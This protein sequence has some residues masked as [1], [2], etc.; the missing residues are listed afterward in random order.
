VFFERKKHDNIAINHYFCAK[1]FNR[2][3]YSYTGV[4]YYSINEKGCP[5]NPCIRQ[6]SK[7]G[8]QKIEELSLSNLKTVIL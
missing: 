1:I 3:L 4:V 2:T 8:K 5:E 6:K 7:A